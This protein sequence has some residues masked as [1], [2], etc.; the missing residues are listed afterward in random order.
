MLTTVTGVSGVRG[1]RPGCGLTAM[2]FRYVLS[3]EMGSRH[4]S[5]KHCQIDGAPKDYRPPRV[6]SLTT[7]IHL[8]EYLHSRLLAC[9]VERKTR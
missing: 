8:N 2:L 9:A 4:I 1:R 7:S 3:R 6:S 5:W